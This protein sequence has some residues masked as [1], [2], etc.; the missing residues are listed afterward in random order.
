MLVG[1]AVTVVGK[2]YALARRALARGGPALRRGTA[3]RR[4]ALERV[5][6]EKLVGKANVA[7]HHLVDV[8]LVGHREV[9]PDV[10]EE[11]AFR[12]GEVVTVGGHSHDHRLA[13]AQDR[14]L[15]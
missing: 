14:F 1:W 15:A 3:H 2:R 4:I 6:D 8:L 9:A 5:L 11:R 10:V 7:A 12:P 13:C